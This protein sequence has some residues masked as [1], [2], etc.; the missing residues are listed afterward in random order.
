MKLIDILRQ[1]LPKR[2]GWPEGVSKISSHASGEVFFDGIFASLGFSLPVADDGWHPSKH[3]FDGT[4]AVTREEYEAAT[5]WNGEGV[6]PVGTECRY[7]KHKRSE[8]DEWFN[9]IIKY[10][11]KFTVVI[12]ADCYPGETVGHPLT[13]EFRP[14]RTEAERAIDEMVQLSGVSIGAAKILYDAGYR[15]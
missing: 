6:P 2:G 7:R 9:G 12:Q 15:K 13:F 4:N 5:G 1:E 3:L 14:I 8:Q 10:A 11:S